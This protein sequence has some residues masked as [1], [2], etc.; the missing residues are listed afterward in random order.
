MKHNLFRSLLAAA[1]AFYIFPI[2]AKALPDWMPGKYLLISRS[3]NSWNAD[4]KTKVTV[5]LQRAGVFRT[6][7]PPAPLWS[8]TAFALTGKIGNN[9]DATISAIVIDYILENKTTNIEV[10][11]IRIALQIDVYKS[12]TFEFTKPLEPN[13]YYHRKDTDT[14]IGLY[15]AKAA[16]EQLV[17][18]WTW[19]YDFV[20]AI[21]QTLLSDKGH[22]AYQAMN[23][24]VILLES[25]H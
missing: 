23:V 10:I 12:A 17:D 6:A 3:I 18:N 16:M 22:D 15:S 13:G 25:T 8:S 4:N 19:R 21:P 2:Q 24:D 11:R 1:I 9:S 20:A 5:D 14:P 7:P